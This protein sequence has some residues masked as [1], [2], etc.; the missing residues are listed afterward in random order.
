MRNNLKLKMGNSIIQDHKF[1]RKQQKTK[2]KYSS[3]TKKK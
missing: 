2:F 3:K 1:P